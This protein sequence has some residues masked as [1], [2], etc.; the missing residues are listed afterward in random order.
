MFQLFTA[1]NDWNKSVS[2]WNNDFSRF[3]FLLKKGLKRLFLTRF[4]FSLLVLGFFIEL[5]FVVVIS[6]HLR[7]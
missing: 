1:V 3:C 6:S 5:Y 2:D 7:P 4:Y